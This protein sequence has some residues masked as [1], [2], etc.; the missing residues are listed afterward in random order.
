MDDTPDDLVV[1]TAERGA[2]WPASVRL[3]DPRHARTA[4]ARWA[5]R[6]CGPCTS[7]AY[8][9]GKPWS[10]RRAT[11]TTTQLLGR[12]RRDTG[13][14]ELGEARRAG[15]VAGTPRCR[16]RRHGATWPREGAADAHRVRVP[17]R[18]RTAIRGGT[19][20][21]LV[22]TVLGGGMSPAVPAGPRR[23]GAR[24]RRLRLPVVSC[25]QRHARRVRRRPRRKRPQQAVAA[26]PRSWTACRARASGREELA[27]R[28]EQLKG[29]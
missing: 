7:R 28:K 25:G 15:P 18:R 29:R 24:V 17:G 5:S 9:P 11:S 20:W 8:Y 2:M 1:R 16:P 26:I 4:S 19:R 22:S 12:A 23:A 13:W 3:F 21:R 14:T 27:G 10:R 6:T